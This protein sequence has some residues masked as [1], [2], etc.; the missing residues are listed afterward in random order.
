MALPTQVQT[1]VRRQLSRVNNSPVGITVLNSDYVGSARPMTGFTPDAA[2]PCSVPWNA[3]AREAFLFK[4]RA[5]HAPED[6]FERNSSQARKSGRNHQAFLVRAE[7]QS[8]FYKR[9]TLQ[10]FAVDIGDSCE[11]AQT[12]SWA[13][14]DCFHRRLA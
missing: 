9:C 7:Y 5:E 14:N 10:P 12:L 13:T 11:E 1:F 6:G 8:N 3:V 4:L 2:L